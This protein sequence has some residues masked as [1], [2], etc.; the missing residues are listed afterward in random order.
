[1][2]ISVTLDSDVAR[3]L[4]KLM[5][6]DRLKFKDAVNQTLLRGLSALEEAEKTEP[7]PRTTRR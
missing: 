7:L 2:R 4:K 3:D 6:K 5:A 1:M